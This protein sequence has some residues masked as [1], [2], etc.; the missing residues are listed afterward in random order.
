[1]KRLYNVEMKDYTSFKAG[2]RA[3]EMV[4]PE[5][6]EELQEALREIAL[7]GRKSIILGNGSNTLIADSGFDGA[8]VKLGEAFC[9]VTVEG[10]LLRA[11]AGTLMSTVART[12]LG[13]DLAGFEFASRYSRKHRRRGIY[14]RGRLWRRDEGHRGLCDHGQPGRPAG[15]DRQRRGYGFRLSPQLS[16][17]KR[18]RGDGGHLEADAGRPRGDRGEDEGTD[19]AEE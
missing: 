1:M 7:N 14:E 10:G 6:T 18:K 3:A 13:A 12:A 8:V 9:R 2:G 4:I 19:P 5:T 17:G 15:A 11:G 16:G